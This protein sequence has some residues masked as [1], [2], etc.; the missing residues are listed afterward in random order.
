M[1]IV[2]I[3]YLIWQKIIKIGLLIFIK[4]I[5]FDLYSYIIKQI[6]IVYTNN[7][8]KVLKSSDDWQQN[9]VSSQQEF[10]L[11]LG[12]I[13]NNYNNTL[14]RIEGLDDELK[15]KLASARM[16]ILKTDFSN[17][18]LAYKKMEIMLDAK[19]AYSKI[20]HY[21]ITLEIIKN[22]LC[23]STEEITKNRV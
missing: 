18:F 11:V 4:N 19:S 20:Y 16:D 10:Y 23:A 14:C 1:K 21:K 12:I 13:T 15:N 9:Y 22:K 8:E 6:K 2:N 3:L 7:A 5:G 17:N